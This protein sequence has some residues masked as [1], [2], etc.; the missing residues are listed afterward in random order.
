MLHQ[1]R[2]P[3][4]AEIPDD[5]P[6]HPVQPAR[7]AQLGQHPV[8]PV[9]VL[10]HLLD[11]HD[12]RIRGHRFD[13]D[14]AGQQAEVAAPQPP[15]RR[16]GHHAA[17]A[18]QLRTRL[19]PLHDQL[20]QAPAGRLVRQLLH[21]AGHRPVHRDLAELAA[22]SAV[23]RGDVG[24]ADE[25]LRPRRPQQVEI[26]QVDHPL[27]AVAAAG[28]PDGCGVR[29]GPGRHEVRGAEPI[30]SG[31]VADVL[32]GRQHLCRVPDRQSPSRDDRRAGL[33]ARRIDRPARPDHGDHRTRRER[34]RPAP[35][36]SRWRAA[37]APAVA[38]GT[39]CRPARRPPAGRRRAAG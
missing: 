18:D 8:Q 35:A 9:A 14:V 20:P 24:E 30:V 11:D 19:R 15:V 25:V 32:R 33:Q 34:R 23:Q 36:F 17:A 13:P 27:G 5:H 1:D 28:R 3:V 38:P 26:E 31:E 6:R 12:H 10:T 21:R 37:H 29:V 22:E 39:W 4:A 7:P 16:A 2:Q